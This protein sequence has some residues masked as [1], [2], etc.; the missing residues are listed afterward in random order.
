MSSYRHLPFPRFDPAERSVGT[1]PWGGA[2]TRCPEDFGPM[3]RNV[4]AGH[5]RMGR[6]EP[7]GRS[8]SW[9]TVRRLPTSR[10]FRLTGA[11]APGHLGCALLTEVLAETAHIRQAHITTDHPLW[12][13][14]VVK[15]TAPGLPPPPRTWA[16]PRSRSC[17]EAASPPG[18]AARQ[19]TRDGRRHT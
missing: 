12:N 7:G 5:L 9:A 15:L 6:G 3:I 19:R 2:H 16:A 4:L 11:P 13:R 10:T 18:N 17:A 14:H 1:T 8:G